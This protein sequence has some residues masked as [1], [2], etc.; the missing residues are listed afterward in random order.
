MNEPMTW[1]DYFFYKVLA[2]IACLVLGWILALLTVWS[3]GRFC[4]SCARR[5]QWRWRLP[6][7]YAKHKYCPYH[8]DQP[9]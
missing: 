3:A 6:H 9:L 4:P 8:D 1:G 7:T 2:S 5:M